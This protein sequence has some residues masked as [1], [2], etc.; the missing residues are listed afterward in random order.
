[1]DKS[2]NVIW[3]SGGLTR[4]DRE[5]Q[6]GQ[7]ACVV[8]FTG[9]PCSGKSTVARAVEKTLHGAGRRVYVLD[10]DNVRHGLCGDLGFSIA[11]RNENIRRVAEVAALLCDGGLIV[12]TAFIS[13]L[14]DER[15]LARSKLPDGRF[16][17]VFCDADLSVCEERDVKG[18]YKRARRGEIDHYTG[19]SSPYQAPQEPELRLDTAGLDVESSA[20]AV[21]ELLNDN[22][23]IAREDPHP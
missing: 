19:I 16:F 17:E 3:Q 2:E 13:P 5:R 11:D 20:R 6:N 14:R 10:G 4:E 22:G 23:I 8:W 18:L 12:L 9:L 7:V 15:L 21:I 1:M